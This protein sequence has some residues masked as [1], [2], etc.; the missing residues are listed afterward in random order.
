VATNAFAMMM[1]ESRKI[2]QEPEVIEAPQI[3]PVEKKLGRPPPI[4]KST[5]SNSSSKSLFLDSEKCVAV[6]DYTPYESTARSLCSGIM[7]C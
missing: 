1:G 7:Y 2:F 5:S 4:K 6:C 3:A